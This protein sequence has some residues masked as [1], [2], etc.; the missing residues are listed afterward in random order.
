MP[1]PFVKAKIGN[2]GHADWTVRKQFTIR[3]K[4]N[5][6]DPKAD[7][8]MDPRPWTCRLVDLKW[9]TPMLLWSGEDDE[10][11]VESGNTHVLPCFY[12]SCPPRCLGLHCSFRLLRRRY[13]WVSVDL[14]GLLPG[15]IFAISCGGLGTTQHK[16]GPNLYSINALMLISCTSFAPPFA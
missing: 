6:T 15:W 13:E 14:L 4:M 9:K 2:R 11:A 16:K 8:Y 12:R 5:P 3:P 7:L 1:L 10:P